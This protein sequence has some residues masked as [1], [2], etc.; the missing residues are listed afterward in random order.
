MRGK[1]N[2]CAEPACLCAEKSIYARK[3]PLYAQLYKS[4]IKMMFFCR[5]AH[6]TTFDYRSSTEI[7][8]I[9]PLRKK[10]PFFTKKE[11]SANGE[12]SSITPV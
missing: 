9:V 8:Q 1:R 3:T 12:P 4:L 2:L 11:G 10:T 5:S 6:N 7:I